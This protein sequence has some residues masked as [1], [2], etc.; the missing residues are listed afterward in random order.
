MTTAD[1]LLIKPKQVDNEIKIEVTFAKNAKW[2]PTTLLKTEIDIHTWLRFLED[3]FTQFEIPTHPITP[4][5]FTIEIMKSQY[6][7]IGGGTH[8]FVIPKTKWGRFIEEQAEKLYL[9][10]IIVLEE[11]EPS[12]KK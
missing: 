10:G 2:V 9:S 7:L 6:K 1:L 5:F 4:G 8:S 12:K 3:C 11:P